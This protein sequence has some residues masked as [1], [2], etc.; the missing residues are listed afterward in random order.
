MGN[1]NKMITDN[2]DNMTGLHTIVI[3]INEAS[4]GYFAIFLL[5]ALFVIS[6]IALKRYD[7]Y[8]AF[9]GASFTTTVSSILLWGGGLLKYEYALVPLIML[10]IG[11]IMVIVNKN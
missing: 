3:A 7:N 8:S 9:V 5:L 4:Y 10:V 1:I 6:F 2:F 11:V